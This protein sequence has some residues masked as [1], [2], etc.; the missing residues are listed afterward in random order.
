MFILIEQ[1]KYYDAQHTAKIY[2]IKNKM[3]LCVKNI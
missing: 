3:Y 1:F 2:A